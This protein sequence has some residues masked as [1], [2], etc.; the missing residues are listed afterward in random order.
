MKEAARLHLRH[1]VEDLNLFTRK[2]TLQREQ[3]LLI[4]T[5]FYC[6]WIQRFA[7]FRVYFVKTEIAR[8]NIS[9]RLQLEA[10]FPVC[11]HGTE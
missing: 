7:R 3:F 9:Y 8:Q 1:R 11:P 5:L 2:L 4:S 6:R 10:A